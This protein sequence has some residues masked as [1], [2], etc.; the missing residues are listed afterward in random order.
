MSNSVFSKFIDDLI[1]RGFEYFGRYYSCY[2]G[3]VVD[4]EDPEHMSRIR[5]IVPEVTGRDKIGK[6]AIPKNVFSGPGYG[7]QVIPPKDTIVWVSFKYGNPKVPLYSLSYH[8]SGD[9]PEDLRAIDNFWF[10]T[11][12]GHIVELDDG[13]KVIRLTHLSKHIIELSEDT[14]DIKHKDGNT[15]QI[16]K[17]DA[18]INGKKVYLGDEGKASHPVALGDESKDRLT[19]LAQ[20]VAKIDADLLVVATVVGTIVSGAT[21]TQIANIGQRLSTLPQLLIDIQKVES[22]KVKTE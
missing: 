13:K 20:Y 9:K 7:S 14:I 6:W 11:P 12:G 18:S 19:D 5:V 16:T 2:E 22:Q 1:R 3:I 10:K 4:N 21:A 15:I 8:A 17:D